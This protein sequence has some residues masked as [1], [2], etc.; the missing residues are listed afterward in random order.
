MVRLIFTITAY[1]ALC[2]AMIGQDTF[3]IVAADSTTN[4]VG[5]AGASCVDL[6]TITI[7]NNDVSFIIELFPGIGAIATQASYIQTNQNRAR[8]RMQA[9]DSPAEIIN[10]VK[11]NDAGNNNAIRQYGVVGIKNN[12]WSTAA[13]TGANCLNYKNH[14]TGSIDGFYYSIQGNILLGQPIIDSMEA[15]FRRTNGN[16]ACRLMEALQGANVVGADTRCAP[17][18]SSSLFAF[19]K[20]SKPED[21]FGEPSFLVNVMTK[22]NAKIEPVDS[23]QVLFDA[24]NVCP[25]NSGV[26]EENRYIS[27]IN[28]VPNPTL[29]YISMDTGIDLVKGDEVIIFDQ[30]GKM[31]IRHPYIQQKMDLDLSHLSSGDYIILVQRKNRILAKSKFVKTK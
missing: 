14:K 25:F 23:L 10:Y 15:R 9:G 4:E 16:L 18:G 22:G 6:F 30:L 3:S 29:G 11:A 2:C 12:V 5:G 31:V 28:I 8:Q 7:P 21:A 17:N 24:S 19:V 20:V 27:N 26:N 13:H 1:F